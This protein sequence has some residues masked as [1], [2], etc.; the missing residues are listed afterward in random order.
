MMKENRDN[1]SCSQRE[2]KNASNFRQK[3]ST[4]LLQTAN[5]ERQ[6]DEESGKTHERNV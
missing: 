5:K 2:N 6:K 3:L 1:R 4:L